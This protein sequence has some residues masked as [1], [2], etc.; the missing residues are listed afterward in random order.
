M[1][2]HDHSQTRHAFWLGNAAIESV[3]MRHRW[4][5]LTLKKLDQKSLGKLGENIVAKWAEQ[6]GFT[7]LFRNL[8]HTG[9]ELDI[10][11]QRM[12]SI[13]ILEIKT[14][15]NPA[16]PPDM[17]TTASWMNRSKQHSLHRGMAY[18]ASQPPRQGSHCQTISVDLIAVDIYSWKQ[19]LTAYRWPNIL[20]D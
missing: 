10:V 6:D 9:F 2:D 18:V 1:L 16:E 19:E 3:S 7:L 17:N 4:S 20:S 15:L 13:Q 8:R 14:R 11:L 5:E 12:K